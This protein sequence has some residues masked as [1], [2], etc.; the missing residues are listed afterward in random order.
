M[1]L[2]GWKWREQTKKREPRPPALR[3]ENV[4]R[5]GR[6]SRNRKSER[7]EFA[8]EQVQR[9]VAVNGLAAEPAGELMEHESG[10]DV[11]GVDR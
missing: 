7:A 3:L 5:A 6:H 11:R 4:T 9:E 2:S 1:V 8:G 10:R